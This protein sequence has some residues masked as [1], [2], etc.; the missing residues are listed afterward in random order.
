[1]A[2]ENA[3]TVNESCT[4]GTSSNKLKASITRSFMGSTNCSDNTGVN[5][6]VVL[7][8]F[9]LMLAISYY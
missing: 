2:N 6:F 7:N 1:M 3:F 8:W 5:R 4:K 9:R